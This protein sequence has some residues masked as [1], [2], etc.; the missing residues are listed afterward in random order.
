VNTLKTKTLELIALATA[1]TI[2]V[3]AFAGGAYDPSRGITQE[4]A[5]TAAKGPCHDRVLHE[6]GTS[7]SIIQPS[8]ESCVMGATL[9]CGC[10]LGLA[11]KTEAYN[12]ALAI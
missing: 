3:P 5:E 4:Q 8:I 7:S 2:S 6:Y 1:L 10:G 9:Y 12:N 11:R